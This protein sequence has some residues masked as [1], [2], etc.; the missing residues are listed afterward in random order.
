MS[1]YLGPKWIWRLVAVMAVMGCLATLA[2]FIWALIW[3][4]RHITFNP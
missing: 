4:A 1:D 3:T 2:M